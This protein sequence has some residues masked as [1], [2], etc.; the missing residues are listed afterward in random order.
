MEMKIEE[1]TEDEK[2]HRYIK[3]G[4]KYKCGVCEKEF[5]TRTGARGHI[6][7]VHIGAKY[8]CDQCDKKYVDL[9]NLKS[10][11]DHIHKGIKFMCDQ[12]EHTSPK[13]ESLKKHVL[14]K[15]PKTEDEKVKP[16]K[17]KKTDYKCS[18]CKKEFTTH[19]GL[20]LHKKSVHEGVR[21]ECEYCGKFFAQNGQLLT[22][23]QTVHQGIK[24]YYKCNQCEYQVT[25]NVFL[26]RHIRLHHVR[27]ETSYEIKEEEAGS[28]QDSQVVLD[29][30]L[31]VFIEKNCLTEK[32]DEILAI[33]NKDLIPSKKKRTVKEN[34]YCKRY[35]PLKVG[36]LYLCEE[37]G[38][39]FKSVVGAQIHMRTVHEGVRYDCHLC[40]RTF[41]Q[42]GNLKTHVQLKHEGLKKYKCGLCDQ[43][44]QE[45]RRLKRH[46]KN[47][48]ILKKSFKKVSYNKTINDQNKIRPLNNE[49]EE[50]T[51]IAEVD[52][53]DVFENDFRNPEEDL[54]VTKG[55][56]DASLEELTK[57]SIFKEESAET[58][59]VN[60]KLKEEDTKDVGFLKEEV[61]SDNT[62]TGEIQNDLDVDESLDIKDRTFEIKTET[63]KRPLE[64]PDSNNQLELKTLAPN[65]LYEKQ[66]FTCN[67]CYQ[68][69]A[70][71]RN[72]ERH[73]KL[74]HPLEFVPVK[75]KKLACDK[76]A[77][78]STTLYSLEKHKNRKHGHSGLQLFYC[79]QCDF[80]SSFQSNLK[81]HIRVRHNGM[82]YCCDKCG[83]QFTQA[84]NLKSHIQII[85][86]G[87]H[88]LQQYM[89][90]QCDYIA[91]RKRTLK[92]HIMIVHDKIR[93]K[94]DQC[95]FLTTTQSNLTRHIKSTHREV[96]YPC[97]KCDKTFTQQGNLKIHIQSV[98]EGMKFSCPHC[99]FQASQKGNLNTHIKLKH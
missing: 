41:S 10:H 96:K 36:D 39:E 60:L 79:D 54:E 76:C 28:I 49:I 95:D 9:K 47:V 91:K 1:S 78:M 98:H 56:T 45:K 5:G 26:K 48:H 83:K 97:E 92:E 4:E 81:K 89:C 73:M 29:D 46:I 50:S 86:D 16:W 94:C 7:S 31:G 14:S 15:H 63:I 13:L 11:V 30:T 52:E 34:R 90:D 58:F 43:Q 18:D 17:S 62:D 23:I 32:I 99:D 66:T 42:E 57:E 84:S 51:C 74:K 64:E 44:F 65:N 80:K 20:R 12:C 72:V 37:C 53:G 55:D 19:T 67:V 2:G 68:N 93:L 82:R 6:R 85:H 71:K 27:D 70:T 77:Y 3:V 59:D 61:F 38:K 33:G 75:K 24:K 8:F 35:K 22:H 69:Y 87:I 88:C 25:K 40:D 21:H